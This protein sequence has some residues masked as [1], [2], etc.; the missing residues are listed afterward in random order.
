MRCVGLTG[1]INW[2]NHSFGYQAVG[3]RG[4]TVPVSEAAGA[5]LAWPEGKAKAGSKAGALG[6]MMRCPGRVTAV[7]ALIAGSGIAMS[8]GFPAI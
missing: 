2:I 4:G 5:A 8:G 7:S 1:K 6:Q 3:A